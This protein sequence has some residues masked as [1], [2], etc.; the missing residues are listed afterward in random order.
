MFFFECVGQILC[1]LDFFFVCGWVKLKIETVH[2]HHKKHN[3]WCVSTTTTT[4]VCVCV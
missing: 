4:C 2:P 3:L 1:V